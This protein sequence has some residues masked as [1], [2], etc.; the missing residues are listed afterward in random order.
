M[1]AGLSYALE[2]ELDRSS[3][4]NRIAEVYPISVSQG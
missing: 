4:W 2:E 3:E 1:G